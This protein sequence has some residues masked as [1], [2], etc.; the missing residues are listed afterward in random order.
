[1]EAGLARPRILVMRPP[2]SSVEALRSVGIVY[3]VP[4][5]R[6]KPIPTAAAEV[7][8]LLPKADWLVLT[9][10]RAPWMLAELREQVLRLRR[11]RGLRVAAVGPSTAREVRRVFGF[12]PDL[13]P[14]RYRGAD[15]ARELLR[16]S[17]RVVVL[18]RAE[19]AVPELREVLA[20]EG[21]E[22]HD[23]PLYTT[24]PDLQAACIAASLA[25][26]VDFI[27]YTSPSIVDSFMKGAEAIGLKPESLP[28][29]H[30]AIGPTT[31][32]RLQSYGIE[33]L[34][35]EEEY[36]LKAVARLIERAV[37]RRVSSNPHP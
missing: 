14:R 20:G 3:H 12:D 23:I 30:V 19:K 36:T 31:A 1:M 6:I 13:V 37:R 25:P 35:P 2:G 29:T 32:R 17:P 8:A 18:A 24:K 34:Y 11:E 21:V 33:P 22:V 7:S 28:A 4:V 26:R 27:V 15:L 10:P 9:S 16:E 5:V